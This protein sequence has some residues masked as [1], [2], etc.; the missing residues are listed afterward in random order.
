MFD[1][2]EPHFSH[3]PNGTTR[4]QGETGP[5]DLER[6]ARLCFHYCMALKSLS[7]AS[8]DLLVFSGQL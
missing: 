2:P 5:Q 7:R 6:P 4:D 1:F 3:L 8:P